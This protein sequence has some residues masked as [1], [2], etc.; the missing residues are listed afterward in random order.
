MAYEKEKLELNYP[1]D[2]LGFNAPK[3]QFWGT[4]LTEIEIPKFHYTPNML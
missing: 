3:A 2:D 4:F 1:P